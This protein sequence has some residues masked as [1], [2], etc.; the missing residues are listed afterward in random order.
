MSELLTQ[1]QIEQVSYLYGL[2]LLPGIGPKSVL[3]IVSAFPRLQLL[4]TLSLE[5]LANTFP[6]PLVKRLGEGL[7]TRW[8]SVFAR[9][10][11]AIN[12]HIERGIFPLPITSSKYPVLLKLIA[13]P[14]PILYIKGDGDILNNIPTIAIIGTR[15]ATARGLETTR[16][17]AYECARRGCVIVSG[18]AKGTDTAAHRGAIAAGG[19]TIAV[20]ATPLDTV[21]PAENKKLAEQIWQ[22]AGVLISEYPIGTETRKGFFVARDR[23]QSGISLGV[24]PVQTDINGGTMHT[25]RHAREQQRPLFCPVP[26][27]EEKQHVKYRGILKLLGQMHDEKNIDKTKRTINPFPL[28]NPRTY[29][30]LLERLEE[31]RVRLLTGQSAY[32]PSPHSSTVMHSLPVSPVI[33]IQQEDQVVSDQLPPIS[34]H[35][36]KAQMIEQPS[37]AAESS[38]NNIPA[39]DGPTASSDKPRGTK[40]VN[41]P[42]ITNA[43]SA[44]NV[45]QEVDN[46]ELADRHTIAEIPAPLGPVEPS[47]TVLEQPKPARSTK[48]SAQTTTAEAEV[49]DMNML[50]AVSTAIDSEHTF[51]AESTKHTP[52]NECERNAVQPTSLQEGTTGPSTEASTAEISSGTLHADHSLRVQIEPELAAQKAPRIDIH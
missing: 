37:F 50:E 5:E 15:E 9:A 34:A 36:T 25:V 35:A 3:S 48:T 42:T 22:E 45:L 33:S 2:S 40:A 41:P 52:I 43:A 19:K 20:F 26:P 6:A 47:A 23:I 31:Q 32:I 14:P 30:R 44:Y 29:D 1:E 24:I 12:Q 10:Q 51:T 39:V 21:Y 4:P 8:R 7:T 16:T 27:E 18:L 46:A 38:D 28:D 49:N 13:D 11:E 17:I